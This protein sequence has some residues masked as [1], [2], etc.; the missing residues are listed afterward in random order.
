MENQTLLKVLRI[1]GIL[2]AISWGALL[3]AMY[4]KRVLGEP[5][6]MQ[7][8][9]MTHGMLFVTFT[10]LV[11]FA[12]ASANWPKKEI[13]LGIIS[14]VLPFGTLWADAKIFKKYV[15]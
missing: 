6:F 9:G 14:A 7:V 13:T 15:K 1:V 8:T 5:K 12:G 10:L 3:I 2:E 11:I 4:Y